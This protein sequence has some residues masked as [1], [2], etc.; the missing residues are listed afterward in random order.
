[1]YWKIFSK[2]EIE[3]LIF[4]KGKEIFKQNLPKFDL[5]PFSTVKLNLNQL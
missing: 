1:M 5:N 4:N 3:I 2:V